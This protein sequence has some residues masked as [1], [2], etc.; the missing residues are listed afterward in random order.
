MNTENKLFWIFG[1]LRA[2]TLGLIIFFV[3]QSL[4]TIGQDTQ[5]VLSGLFPTFSLAV[6]Y[7]IYSKKQGGA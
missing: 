5:L 7:L 3:L 4:T 1:G 6:E 2:V